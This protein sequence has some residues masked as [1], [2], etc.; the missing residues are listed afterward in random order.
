MT[1]KAILFGV[2]IIGS[3]IQSMYFVRH[4]D[5]LNK[6][7]LDAFD[8]FKEKHNKVYGSVEDHDYRLSVFV[9]N[10]NYVSNIHGQVLSLKL[11]NNKFADLNFEEFETLYLSN[12]PIDE[13]VIPNGLS[14]DMSFLD[15]QVVYE[16]DWRA[17]N[18]VTPV[19]HQL[20]C[21][22]C[23]AFSAAATLESA[24]A[25]KYNELT[26]LSVMELV[27]CSEDYENVGCN[28]GLPHKAYNYI[29]DNKIGIESDYRF[30][31]FRVFCQADKRKK[32]YEMKEYNFIDPI[33]ANGLVAAININ[34]V[35]I[36]FEVRKD[37]QLIHSDTY[38]STDPTC[39]RVIN[40]AMTAVGYRFE[41]GEGYFI[42]KNSWGEDWA[43]KGYV[44]IIVRKGSNYCGMVS[45]YSVYPVL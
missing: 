23:W 3:V 9:D 34:P 4:E 43:D 20:Y 32:N 11:A 45:K 10:L 41:N 30:Q 24:I 28:G 7:Y 38:E 42:I 19:K 13:N 26:N 5:M 21:G 39:G 2:L 8:T 25:I 33:S 14:D 35:A 15:A 1:A 40:H 16:K 22:S 6:E 31:P 18:K 44:K 17:E 37:F 27:D 12:I 36:L 29:I